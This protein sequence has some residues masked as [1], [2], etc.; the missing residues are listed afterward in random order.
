MGSGLYCQ[1]PVVKNDRHS[2]RYRQ[3]HRG[4][5]HNGRRRAHVTQ[6][7]ETV[8]SLENRT[9]ED[10]STGTTPGMK[11]TKQGRRLP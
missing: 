4:T 1:I 2:R 7:E 3:Q 5:A 8:E 10:G 6:T 9:T 11:P